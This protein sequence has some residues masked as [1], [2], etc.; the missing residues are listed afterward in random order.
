MENQNADTSPRRDIHHSLKTLSELA[1][2]RRLHF[3]RTNKAFTK[4]ECAWV[5]DSSFF[6]CG[7]EL[8]VTSDGE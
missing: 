7:H 4:S 5:V 2:T 1:E 8:D 6:V 3:E